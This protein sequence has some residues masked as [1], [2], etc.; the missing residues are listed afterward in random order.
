MVLIWSANTSPRLQYVCSFIF[1]EQMQ[2]DFEI[3]EDAEKFRQY[4]F[5]LDSFT[6]ALESFPVN[7]GENFE[8]YF[9]RLKEYVNKKFKEK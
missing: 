4:N 5:L 6:T 2:A 1:K 3:T 8:N 9:L 7:K